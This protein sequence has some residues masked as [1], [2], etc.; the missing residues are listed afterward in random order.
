[1]G[2]H[3]YAGNRNYYLPQSIAIVWCPDLL[4]WGHTVS[5]R[6]LT[7]EI[8]RRLPSV[9]PNTVSKNLKTFFGLVQTQRD[10]RYTR[11]RLRDRINDFFHQD[12][13]FLGLRPVGLP[14]A[15]ASF[16]ALAGFAD[17][18]GSTE[19]ADVLLEVFN[20]QR[21]AVVD[22]ERTSSIYDWYVALEQLQGLV[23]PREIDRCLRSLSRR[24]DNVHHHHVS[25]GGYDPQMERLLDKMDRMVNEMERGRNFNRGIAFP[26][27]RTLPPM[28]PMQMLMPAA[29]AWA[30]AY[31][32]PTLSAR[33]DYFRDAEMEEVKERLENLEVGQQIQGMQ[34]GLAP[35][36]P[37]L[38]AIG[39]H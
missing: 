34:L 14:R 5:T 27:S 7:N 1:M 31:A 13:S 10:Y 2:I 36:S 30:S 28:P 37:G 9:I 35:P 8:R 26:R 6:D 12:L 22:H 38:A 32:S 16:T 15:R 4:N 19:L 3:I 24:R 23:D 21:D 17:L 18:S 11:D 29:P 20:I 25:R 33:E 39:W